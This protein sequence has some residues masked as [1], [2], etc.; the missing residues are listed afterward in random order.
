[1]LAFLSF[2]VFWY[3]K[4]YTEASSAE[5][6]SWNMPATSREEGIISEASFA[7]RE[8]RGRNFDNEKCVQKYFLSHIR[9]SLWHVDDTPTLLSDHMAAPFFARCMKHHLTYA[10]LAVY[11]RH[12]GH[13]MNETFQIFW[14]DKIRW[15]RGMCKGRYERDGE[16]CVDLRPWQ[17]R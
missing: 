12:A 7:K 5:E 13:E 9:T 6:H 3:C 8:K 11:N 15:K 10:Y 16:V 17:V 2:L 4:N 1:M 14:D